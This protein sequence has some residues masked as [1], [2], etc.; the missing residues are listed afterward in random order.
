MQNAV[1]KLLLLTVLLLVACTGDKEKVYRYAGGKICL[2]TV[3]DYS[4]LRHIPCDGN[5]PSEFLLPY[6]TFRFACGDLTGDGLPEIG[7][8]VIKRTR[9]SPEP[10]KRLWVFHLTEG[11]LIRPLWMGSHV[12]GRL[13]DFR[14]DGDRIVTS[15]YTRTDSLVQRTYRLG[16][17]GLEYVTL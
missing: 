5:A 15:E 12:G 9:F 3:G 17:F 14:F 4:I 2:E 11:R 16:A 10:D 8:G 6:P 7:V 1:C 13:R